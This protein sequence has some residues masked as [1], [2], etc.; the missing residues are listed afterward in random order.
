MRWVIL[1]VLLFPASAAAQR[2]D[3]LKGA[4]SLEYE[5][6]IDERRGL[7]GARLRGQIGGDVIGYRI[8]VDLF[9]GAASP[10]GFAYDCAF[11]PMGLGLRLGKWSR[12]GVVGGIAANDAVMLP[13]EASL[14]LGL[15]K[16]LR[17]IARAR[18]G[19]LNG[20]PGRQDGSETVPW[21][22]ELD[23][24]FSI[25]IGKRKHDWGFY[26]GNGYYLGV[27]YR[28]AEGSR[29]VG[30]VVGHSIDAGT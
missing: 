22:D 18:L 21:A 8:G 24:S 2:W 28:E 6:R 16:H 14:E 20:A 7:A 23:A 30:V 25:R 13:A 4:G 15:G 26:A 5:A 12:L 27:G 17:V 10:A 1:L 11:Y 29:Y 3:Q 19:W 9:A